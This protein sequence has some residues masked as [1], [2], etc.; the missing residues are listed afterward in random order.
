MVV[1]IGLAVVLMGAVAALYIFYGNVLQ[2]QTSVIGVAHGADAVVS[3]VVTAGLQADHVVASHAFS[4]VT[5]AS[6]TTSAIFELPSVGSTGNVI[7]GSYDYIG[8]YA[9]GTN[10]YQ[11][12]DAASTSARTSREKFLTT[13]LGALSFSYNGQAF[14][15]TT[16]VTVDATTSAMVKDTNFRTHL[17]ESVHL[18]NL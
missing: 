13:A 15:S 6:G 4:G 1:A 8:F 5:Y 11:I 16:M 2:G 7:P 10:A 17:R 9:S 12:V 18:R 14:A 3:A